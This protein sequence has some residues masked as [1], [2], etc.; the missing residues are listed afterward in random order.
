MNWLVPKPWSPWIASK[1]AAPLDGRPADA[2]A[3]RAAPT[4]SDGTDSAPEGSMRNG[5][6]APRSRSVAS[7]VDLASRPACSGTKSGF[8]DQKNSHNPSAM[9]PATSASSPSWRTAGMSC[10]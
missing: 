10:R 1:P 7:L 5:I 8:C 2:S 3:M 4:W 6:C 9:V